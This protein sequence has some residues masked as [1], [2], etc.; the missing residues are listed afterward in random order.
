[1]LKG[2]RLTVLIMRNT[3]DGLVFHELAQNIL[4]VLVLFENA[5]PLAYTQ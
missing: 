4:V 3:T 5:W 1:M 2:D